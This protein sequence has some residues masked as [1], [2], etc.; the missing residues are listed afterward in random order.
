[1]I[2]RIESTWQSA[3]LQGEELAASVI[4]APT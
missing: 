3:M 1:M 2:H 4:R